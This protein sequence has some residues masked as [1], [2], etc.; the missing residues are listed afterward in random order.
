MYHK[1]S[2]KRVVFIA[3]LSMLIA[4]FLPWTQLTARA[5]DDYFAGCAVGSI[6]RTDEEN[7]KLYFYVPDTA[8]S[9]DEDVKIFYHV[10]SKSDAPAAINLL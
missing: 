6:L 5:E 2:I 4:V 9:A 1:F 3:L 8:T 7:A 10:R